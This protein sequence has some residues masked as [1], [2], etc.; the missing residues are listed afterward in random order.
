MVAHKWFDIFAVSA[1]HACLITWVLKPSLSAFYFLFAPQIFLSNFYAFMLEKIIF[2]CTS[3]CSLTCFPCHDSTSALDE[4]T[5]VV[6]KS[7]KMKK[8]GRLKPSEC[9]PCKLQ[10]VWS[11][12]QQTLTNWTKEAPPAEPVGKSKSCQRK[13]KIFFCKEK[14]RLCLPPPPPSSSENKVFWVANLFRP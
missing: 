8:F 13:L 7:L 9:V 14:N 10:P 4:D 12:N 6:F 5:N 11:M 3:A 2:S 1:A